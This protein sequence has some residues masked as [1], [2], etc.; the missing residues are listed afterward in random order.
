MYAQFTTESLGEGYKHAGWHLQYIG[1][2]SAKQLHGIGS[3]LIRHVEAEAAKSTTGKKCFCLET[4]AVGPVSFQ[5][6]LLYLRIFTSYSSLLSTRRSV[7]LKRARRRSRVRRNWTTRYPCGA[8]A[9]KST[10]LNLVL[11]VF[12]HGQDDC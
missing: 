3:A 11:N 2:T 6:I 9:R 7:T 8:S 10:E 12:H 4:E 1:V 5:F